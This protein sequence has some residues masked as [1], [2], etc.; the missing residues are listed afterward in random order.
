MDNWKRNFEQARK[1]RLAIL[2]ISRERN[3]E[4]RH[5]DDLEEAEMQC[6]MIDAKEIA[7]EE[8]YIRKHCWG[9]E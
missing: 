8:A 9:G 6:A 7:E 2:E 5:I 3:G 1:L 4:S